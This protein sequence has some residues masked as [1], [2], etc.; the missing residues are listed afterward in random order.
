MFTRFSMACAEG[1]VGCQTRIYKVRTNGKD[2]RLLVGHERNGSAPD[3][4][5]TGLA[6]TF[7][8]HDTT[9]APNE[10]HIMVMLPDGSHK[11]VIVRGD[12]DSHYGNP[13]FSPDGT[14]VAF[15]H[16]PLGPDGQPSQGSSI[17]TAWVTGAKLRQVTRD[18]EDNKAD[19]GPRPRRGHG[20]ALTD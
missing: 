14:R 9:F 5:P 4:H 20:R 16:W 13:S 18:G 2:L 1:P 10:G 6:I 12:A 19:W 15:T 7:D 8:V 17:W 11:R 3:W